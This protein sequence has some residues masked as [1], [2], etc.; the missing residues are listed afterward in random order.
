MNPRKVSREVRKAGVCVLALTA[1]L[2]GPAAWAH[3]PIAECKAVD[4]QTI[5]CQGGFSDGSDAPGVTL[6]VVSYD[7]KVLLPGKLDNDS[8]LRFK[9]PDSDFYILFDA[10]PGHVVEIDQTEIEETY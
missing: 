7:E 5:E 8:K 9:R 1:L 2:C 10:G 6:D 4:A 3:N